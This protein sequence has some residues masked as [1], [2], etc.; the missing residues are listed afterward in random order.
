MYTEE[1]PV[2]LHL[3]KFEKRAYVYFLFLLKVKQYFDSLLSKFMY[4]K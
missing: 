1:F 4:E 2:D 3:Y